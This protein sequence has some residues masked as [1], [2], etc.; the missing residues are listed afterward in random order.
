MKTTLQDL[1]ASDRPVT[2]DG[3]MGT[4]LIEL[5]LEVGVPTGVW[6]VDQPDRVGKVH[7]DFIEAGAQIILTNTFVCNR[8]S[9]K[10]YDLADRAVELTRAAAR[11][12]RAEADAADVPVAVGGSIGPTGDILEPLGALSQDEARETFE[13]QAEVLAAGGVDVFWIETMSDPEEVRAAVEGCRRVDPDL[14][15]VMTMSFERGGRTL[16]G[17]TPAQAM[18]AL[19]GFGAVAVG[20]NCGSSLD[21]IEVVIDEMHIADPGAV[22]VAK[23]NAGLPRTEGDV[24]AYD[25]T[26]EDMAD[27]AKAVYERGAR[28]IGACC[29][30][31][32]AHIR[33]I[34][35]TLSNI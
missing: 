15:V 30:S 31:T 4:N 9:L 21:E 7:R 28:I 1:V 10:L 18:E 14:P 19:M 26:P 23:A 5:G 27:Y 25:A 11:V 16:M 17:V 12:A 29:G 3:A 2:V 6:N 22:L 33:A 13:Q 34:A 32:P 20:G 8:L 35:H 24:T